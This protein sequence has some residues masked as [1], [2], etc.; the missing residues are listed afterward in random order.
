MVVALP[1]RTLLGESVADCW[2]SAEAVQPVRERAGPIAGL[3][4]RPISAADDQGPRLPASVKAVSR[5]YRPKTPPNTAVF[6]VLSSAQVPV[7]TGAP[8]FVPSLLIEIEYWPILP[9]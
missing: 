7:T 8:Q 2:L 5:T 6:R 3:P 1:S 9:L 4:S